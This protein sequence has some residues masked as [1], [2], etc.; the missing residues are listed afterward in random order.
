MR[1][2]ISIWA[3]TADKS[4]E[5]CFRLAKDAGFGAVEL[6]YAK[7]GFIHP[8]MSDK[9]LLDIHALADSYGLALPTLASGIFWGINPISD[10]A[11]ERAEAKVHAREMLRIAH[12]LGAKTILFVP[13][14]IGPFMAGD[15]AVQDYEVAYNRAI[16]DFKELAADAE[17]L[18]VNLGIENVWN[19]FL[20][21]AHGDARLRRRH[22][23][24]LRGRLLRRRQRAA[25]QLPAAVDQDP[26]QA[27]QGRA[28]QGLPHAAPARST[29]SW[30]CW[31]ATSTDTAVM[32]AFAEAGID[33]YAV[34][35]QFPPQQYPDAMIY[36]AAQAADVIFGGQG[37]VKDKIRVGV[38]GLGFMGRAHVAHYQNIPGA[39]LVALADADPARRA[40][41]ANVQ[42]NIEVPLPRL[43]VSEFQV[44]A[45]GKDLIA[46]ADVDLVDI[47]MPTYLHAEFA[48]AAAKA[49]KHV[50]TEKPM[51]LSSAECTTHDRRGEGRGRR[52]D[53]RP[54]PALLARVP[55]P[56]GRRRLRP[57]RQ[58]A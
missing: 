40:G 9:E 15:P 3:F 39:E 12:V 1:K 7:D 58:A 30:S 34:V 38:I 18:Q 13:G 55:L 20:D 5:D 51:A 53:D 10:N 27:H 11:D 32:A 25:H 45:D 16:V 49:G 52:A 36:R 2:A 26:G 43:D 21:F 35:E 57:L 56:Q 19:R 8:G 41:G 48:I 17:R 6:A 44:F 28:L 24:P 42:G 14:S 31:R 33:G 29:A 46:K 37:E 47:C 22:R 23:Q 50:V 54:V 4:L